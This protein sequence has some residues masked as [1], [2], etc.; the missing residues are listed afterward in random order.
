MK[1]IS[2]CIPCFNEVDNVV[3]MARV[4]TEI[5]EKLPQYDYEIIFTDNCSTDGTRDKLR[6]LAHEDCHIKVLMNNRNYGC[7]DG[8]SG[9]NTMRYI[10]GEVY[11]GLPCDFQEPPELIPQFISEWENGYKVVLGQK[12]DS[13]ENKIKYKCRR[14]YYEIIDRFSNIPQYTNV[15]GIV[16]LDKYVVNELK[17]VD[18]DIYVRNAIADMGI[19]VKLIKYKQGKRHAG[20]SSYNFNRYLNFAITGMVNT[21]TIPLRIATV[22]GFIVSFTSFVIGIVYLVLKLVFWDRFN[23]GMTPLLIGMFFIGAVL[24]L[25]VGIVGEYVGV[26]LRKVTHFPRVFTDETINF[27]EE[28]A[29]KNNE[30]YHKK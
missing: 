12:I 21:S 3:P 14:L 1:K 6:L 27:D 18:D 19:K 17:E 9:K 13:E 4:L 16:L 29:H 5:M 10:S 20:K 8:R 15:S 11:I 25:S 2:L 24:L 30:N 7:T 23:A 28:L 26:V 22:L